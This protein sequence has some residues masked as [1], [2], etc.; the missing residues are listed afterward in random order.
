[1]ESTYC[2]NVSSL[3]LSLFTL[4]VHFSDN[5]GCGM[6]HRKLYTDDMI[7]VCVYRETDI[8]EVLQTHAVFVNVS[9]G[10]VANADDLRRVFSTDDQKEI[11]LQVITTHTHKHMYTHGYHDTATHFRGVDT[12]L[13]AR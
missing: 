13:K 11:C 3:I 6:L 9:K 1:M 4:Y 2:V 12:R 10:Q 8:D 7:S 5:C